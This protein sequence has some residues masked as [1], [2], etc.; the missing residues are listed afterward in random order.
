MTKDSDALRSHASTARDVSQEVRTLTDAEQLIQMANH[1]EAEADRLEREVETPPPAEMTS[2]FDADEKADRKDPA[3]TMSGAP[4]HELELALK[5]DPGDKQAQVDV[6][7]DGSMDASDPPAVCQPG[8][9]DPAP[10]NDF[11][12]T[13]LK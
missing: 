5:R 9:S 2:I 13:E 6:G 10:S 7:S 12:N 11:P 1:M 4:D 3:A 8:G